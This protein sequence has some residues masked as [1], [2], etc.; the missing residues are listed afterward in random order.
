M[1]VI[2]FDIMEN[3]IKKRNIL[4]CYFLTLLKSIFKKLFFL[5]PQG[6]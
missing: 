2:L 4:T 5:L 3:W 6:K 1:L